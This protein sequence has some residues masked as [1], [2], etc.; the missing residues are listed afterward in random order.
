MNNLRVKIQE[1]LNFNNRERQYFKHGERF[2]CVKSWGG[3]E[4]FHITDMTNA[5]VRGATCSELSVNAKYS[6]PPL[7]CFNELLGKDLEKLFELTTAKESP[8]SHFGSDNFNYYLR[9]VESKRLMPLDLSMIRPLKKQPKKWT[10]P[11]AIRAIVNGQ[12][13]SLRCKYRHLDDTCQDF[14]KGEISDPI[15][16]ARG[17]IE[18]PSGWWVRQ[19]TDGMVTICCHSFDS[20]EFRPKIEVNEKKIKKEQSKLA[21]TNKDEIQ[22]L[23]KSWTWRSSYF[24]ITDIKKGA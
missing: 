15:N 1:K 16:F 9:E 10:I 5:G 18:D 8:A 2:Y 13:E 24:D 21:I 19:T 22:T 7:A 6:A 4:N 23:D 14:G 17:I 3:G 20:N 12:Y 11:H